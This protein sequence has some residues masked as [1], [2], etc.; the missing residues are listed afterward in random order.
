MHTSGTTAAPKPVVLTSA[1][2]S[3]PAR[4]ARR[5]RSG[6]TP[7]SAGCARC[8][9]RTSA[10]SR[11]R[12]AA[13]STRPRSSCTG[14][15]TPRR[16]CDELMDPGRRITLVSLVPTMLARL[17]DAGLARPPTLRWALLGGGPIAP[18]LLERARGGRRARRADVR[19]DRGLLA[20]RHVRLAAAGRRAADLRR[21]RG[22]RARPDRVA[23]ARWPTTAGCTPAT[24][25]ASTS[26][27]AL[28][29]IGR[30]SDTIVSGGEN[31][32]PAEVEAALLEHPAVADAAV[33][34]R[35]RPGVGGGGGRDGR[36]ARRHDADARGAARPL[37]GAAGAV[38]GAQ[39]GRAS[40]SSCRGRRR[41][42]CSGA[43]FNRW[44]VLRCAVRGVRVSQPA[45]D[46]AAGGASPG[47]RCATS[48]PT[49]RAG[50]ST[51][52]RCA[53][54]SATTGPSTSRSCGWSASSRTTASTSAGSSGCSTTP[55]APRS[56]CGGSAR[57]SAP[58]RA[59]SPARR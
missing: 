26:A 19:H 35:A 17:L 46:R 24:S 5:W 29:I 53:H 58:P 1:A 4:S 45:D 20:D 49:R 30:K 52:P 39:G 54:A 51:R 37:R 10:G 47:C 50:C 9:S 21:R 7:T 2:T 25:G 3:W 11:S 6:S 55:R 42:S 40:P 44:R 32:A 56:G 23:P 57:R 8:R 13:R 15:S 22:A 28:E 18:A 31:V 43:S 33:H 38:Q 34:P 41:A 12:S 59:P 27:G 48:A 16:C 14:G 36:A